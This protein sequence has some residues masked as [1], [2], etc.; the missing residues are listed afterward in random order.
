MSCR[1]RWLSETSGVAGGI[2]RCALIRVLLLSLFV[3]EEAEGLLD[4]AVARDVLQDLLGAADVP[5]FRHVEPF[6]EDPHQHRALRLHGLTHGEAG[7]GALFEQQHAETLASEDG[8][9]RSAGDT[10]TEHGNVILFLF[11]GFSPPGA[12]SAPKI[13]GQEP[14]VNKQYE[15]SLRWGSARAPPKRDNFVGKIFYGTSSTF[16]VVRRPSRARWASAASAMG[17]SRPMCSRSFPSAIQPS[18]S[19]ARST[20]SSR[21]WM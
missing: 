9:Q 4:P 15:D 6:A 13:S 17:S 21:R 20:S 11:H 7:M 8:R 19:R 1:N 12:T 2:S 14:Q 18:T 3:V 5:D 10:G 16:P